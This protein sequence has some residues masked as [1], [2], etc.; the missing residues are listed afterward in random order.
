MF[1]N[2]LLYSLSM[3]LGYIQYTVLHCFPSL[4]HRVIK[5]N[6]KNY[7]LSDVLCISLRRELLFLVTLNL[8]FGFYQRILHQRL[9]FVTVN[10][11]YERYKPPVRALKSGQILKN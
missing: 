1:P 4:G 6:D 10:S 7:Q 8:A 5:R 3:L 2:L 11:T 9:L